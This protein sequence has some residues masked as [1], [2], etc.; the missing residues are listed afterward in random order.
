MEYKV[1][2]KCKNCQTKLA[3][4]VNKE[5]FGSNI[6][7]RCKN[8]NEIIPVKIPEEQVFL[9]KNKGQKQDQNKGNQTVIRT[10]SSDEIC[11]ILQTIASEYTK[12]QK[13]DIDQD[14]MTIGRKNQAGPKFRPDLEVDTQD[15][16]MS[17][18]HAIFFRK[19]K[20]AIT[21]SDLNSTNG[22]WLNGEKLK[23]ND[24]EYLEDGDQLKIGRTDFK[25][26]FTTT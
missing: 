11:I 25:I 12:F 26:V 15:K 8:C 16:Y 6:T 24:E 14:R 19:G 20:E 3:V 4:P 7:V 17:K 22:T 1:G 9:N 21:V 5:M 10:T 18:V 2:I 13:F 23:P